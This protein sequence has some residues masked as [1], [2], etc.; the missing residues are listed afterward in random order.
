MLSSLLFYLGASFVFSNTP[1]FAPHSQSVGQILEILDKGEVAPNLILVGESNHYFLPFKSYYR[2]LFELLVSKDRLDCVFLESEGM[3]P[4][5]TKEF[6]RKKGIPIYSVGEGNEVDSA[7]M[8]FLELSRRYGR[9]AA[10]KKMQEKGLVHLIAPN[11]KRYYFTDIIFRRNLEMTTAIEEAY[12]TNKCS[13]A[14]AIAGSDHTFRSGP[15]GSR[16]YKDD[17]IPMSEIFQQTNTIRTLSIKVSSV[18]AD[19]TPIHWVSSRVLG[20]TVGWS[21]QDYD[22]LVFVAP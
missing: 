12:T 8:L 9:A 16:I 7:T 18:G 21:D 14:V 15:Q 5:D 13:K 11:P 1:N 20:H 22:A 17:R 4:V 3:L 6:L 10:D 2:S 19:S